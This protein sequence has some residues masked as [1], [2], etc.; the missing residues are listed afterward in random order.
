MKVESAPKAGTLIAWDT[1]LML[2]ADT[3]AI[4]CSLVLELCR[5]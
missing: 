5:R 4:C 3:D 1:F 2:A